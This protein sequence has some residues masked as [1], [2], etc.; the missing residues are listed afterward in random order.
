MNGQESR[1]DDWLR[2]AESDF[3]FAK[4]ALR[5]EFYSHCCF[6][7]QQAAEKALESIAYRRGATLLITHSLIK[8]CDSLQING[9]LRRGAGILDQYYLAARYPDALP[10]GAPCDVYVKS[11]ADEAIQTAGKIIDAAYKELHP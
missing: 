8:L 1:A 11:Q 10:G 3:L 2:Q 7:C 9:E 4:S 6:I 5:D